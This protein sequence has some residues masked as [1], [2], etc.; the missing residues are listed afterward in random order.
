M[1]GASEEILAFAATKAI[2]AAC[3]LGTSEANVAERRV[4]VLEARREDLTRT[5]LRQNRNSNILSSTLLRRATSSIPNIFPFY[6]SFYTPVQMMSKKCRG[7]PL[8]KMNER[9]NKSAAV[10]YENAYRGA[11]E[12]L[13]LIRLQ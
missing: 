1:R 8:P 4:V 11:L 5:F 3:R 9:E 7:V 2:V 13:R 12:G 6:P 10:S